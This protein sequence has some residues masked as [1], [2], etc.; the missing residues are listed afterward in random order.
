MTGRNLVKVRLLLACGLAAAVPV[1]A[2]AEP[3][4]SPLSTCAPHAAEAATRSALPENI[5]LR[6]MHVES[7]GRANAISPKGAMGCMQ[8]MP[9]TWRYLTARHRLGGDPW[10]PRFN[11]IGGALYLAELARQ[12]GFP[13]AYAAY[14]AGPARYA[15]HVRGHAPLPAE[16]V[17]YMASLSGTVLPRENA[18]TVA[19]VPP[20]WQ[21]AGLFLRA[22]P[23]RAATDDG[24]RP[25]AASGRAEALNAP[26]RTDKMAER[27]QRSE[28]FPL[29][30]V[31]RD[32]FDDGGQA[33]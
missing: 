21:D 2:R 1:P 32:G 11:M 17:A 10:D 6:V 25:A 14:N 5:I 3:S 19:A 23:V 20:R 22:E 26:V 13:G 7:R 28:L 33:E 8:I 27:P 29:A 12:F 9:A 15:R 4:P 31:D 18:R 30:R 24:A 16:T